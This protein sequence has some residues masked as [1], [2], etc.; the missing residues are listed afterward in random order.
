M[1]KGCK[2]IVALFISLIITVGVIGMISGCNYDLIDTEF[3]YNYA[4][5]KL[6]DGTLIKGKVESWHDYEGEQL[7]VKIDGV[8]YLTNSYNCTLI[9]DPNLK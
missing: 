1:S 5:I 4:Y 6:Q 8:L 3:K 9:Y 2:Y 7:Q